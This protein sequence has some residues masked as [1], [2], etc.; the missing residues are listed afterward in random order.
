MAGKSLNFWAMH[1][2]VS[3]IASSR[4]QGILEF[5]SRGDWRLFIGVN[6]IPPA[7][8]CSWWRLLV[9]ECSLGWSQASHALGS[10]LSCHLMGPEIRSWRLL[11]IPK[12]CHFNGEDDDQ[13]IYHWPHWG[14]LPLS[15]Q[16]CEFADFPTM[17]ILHSNMSVYWRRALLLPVWSLNKTSIKPDQTILKP[18]NPIVW[19][20]P[21]VGVPANHP[22]RLDF[23]SKTIQLLGIPHFRKPTLIVSS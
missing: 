18:I 1:R 8:D 12:D 3:M 11:M 22:F 17:A 20:F 4:L 6:L 9:D 16:S 13:S 23:S 2:W 14:N 5:M 10:Y 15:S 7:T 21:R 19:R